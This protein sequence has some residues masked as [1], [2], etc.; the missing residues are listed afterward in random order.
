MAHRTG[1]C[2]ETNEAFKAVKAGSAMPLPFLFCP[3]KPGT[4][5]QD[6]LL[7]SSRSIKLIQRFFPSDKKLFGRSAHFLDPDIIFHLTFKHPY[8]IAIKTDSLSD[9]RSIS[10]ISF[11]CEQL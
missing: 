10:H 5:G 3:E 8:H 4:L 6:S 2:L 1:K 7:K 9:S 11:H